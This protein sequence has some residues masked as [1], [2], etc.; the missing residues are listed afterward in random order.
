ME[1]NATK[2]AAIIRLLLHIH[3]RELESLPDG[4]LAER[5]RFQSL[6]EANLTRDYSVAPSGMEMLLNSYAEKLRACSLAELA[7]LIRASDE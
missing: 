1:Q 6:Q 2:K 3:Q 4:D 7:G 5:V